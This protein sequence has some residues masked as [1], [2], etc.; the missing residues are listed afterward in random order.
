LLV[1]ICCSVDSHFFLQQL[2]NDFPNEEIECFF[3]DPNI[4]PYSEYALRL[5][6]VQYSCNK[7]GINL[8]EGAY[9]INTWFNKVK[10]LELEPEKGDRC[11]VCFDL[12]LETTALKALELNHKSFTTTLLIS[13]KKSQDKLQIIGDKLSKQYNIE[14]I[15]KDYR[16]GQGMHLQAQQ[17]KQNSLYRQNYC[18]CMFGLIPQRQYQNRLCDELINPINKQILPQSIENRLEIYHQ[19]NELEKQNIKYKIVKERFLNYRIFSAKVLVDKEV[20]PSYFLAYSTL[21]NKKT[22]GKIE[23][24]KDNISYLN[25]DETK[26]ITLD[27]FNLK[28]NTNYNNVKELMFNPP[29]FKDELN[30]RNSISNSA[31]NL[32]TIIILDFIPSEKI[33]IYCESKVYEDEREV[34]I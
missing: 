4:Q 31:F 8:I 19:R 1:H 7:L 3:Y 16:I 13:P 25:K 21:K 17:V 11:T 18:G 12:R 15:F 9:D 10:G 30:F 32:C 27:F 23:Y 34:I 20:I 24:T 26:I 28:I 33:E 5:L 14:F 6:D 2:Q 22:K 29:S